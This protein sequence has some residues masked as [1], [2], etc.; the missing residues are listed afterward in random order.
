[1]IKLPV[2]NSKTMILYAD[3]LED[4]AVRMASEHRSS[5]MEVACV[6]FERGRVLEDYKAYGRRAH[7]GGVVY[8]QSE[9]EAFAINLWNEEVQNIDTSKYL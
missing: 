1:H 4:M 9:Q 7:F 2:R 3:F 8:L 6:R 5:G